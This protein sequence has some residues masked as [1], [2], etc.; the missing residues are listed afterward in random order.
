M[1]CETAILRK[2][3]H[4]R[5]LRTRELS[6]SRPNGLRRASVRDFHSF[7]VT[8]V[9]LALSAGVPLEIV[10][11]VTGHRMAGIVM[12]HYFQPGREEFRRTLAEKLPALIGGAPAPKA[13]QPTKLCDQLKS[14]GDANWRSVRDV[15]VAKLELPGAVKAVK[16]H[17]TA[18]AESLA[19]AG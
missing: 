3:A 8:W 2:K 13:L 6:Q 4:R 5:R 19:I 18:K 11:K 15:L 12:K 17:V 9:T 14:M 1:G 10:Q 7:R 16:T